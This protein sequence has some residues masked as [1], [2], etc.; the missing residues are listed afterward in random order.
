VIS[1]PANPR[2]WLDRLV[3]VCLSILIGATA[4]F[5]TVRLI[6]A[7]WTALLVILLVAGLVA[8]AVVAFRARHGGW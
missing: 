4:V 2:G 8:L 5:I 3:G 7:V 6:E 1:G